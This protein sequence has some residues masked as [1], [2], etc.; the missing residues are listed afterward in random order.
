MAPIWFGSGTAPNGFVPATSAPGRAP[1]MLNMGGTPVGV[2]LGALAAGVVGEGA[3]GFGRGV[4]FGPPVVGGGTASCWAVN[5]LAN[6]FPPEGA[7]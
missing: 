4:E 2:V 3:Q 6:G 5:K 7:A 1:N